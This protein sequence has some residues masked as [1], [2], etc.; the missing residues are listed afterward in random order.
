[1][2]KPDD[3]IKVGDSVELLPRPWVTPRRKSSHA[4]G[5]AMLEYLRSSN[6]AKVTLTVDMLDYDK[7]DLVQI[8]RRVGNDR[9]IQVYVVDLADLTFSKESDPGSC[10]FL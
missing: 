5:P 8:N 2:R 6:Q 4:E 7:P 10:N 1:M 9:F 3:R